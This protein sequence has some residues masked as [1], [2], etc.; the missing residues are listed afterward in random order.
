MS[1]SDDE[2]PI[3][4]SFDSFEDKKCYNLLKIDQKTSELEHSISDYATPSIAVEKSR[5]RELLEA[6]ILQSDFKNQNDQLRR[7]IQEFEDSIEA[8]NLKF[9]SFTKKYET[10]QDRELKQQKKLLDRGKKVTELETFNS[11]LITELNN[12]ISEHSKQ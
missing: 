8:S 3:K 12:Q 2:D 5:F 6:E 7:R 10:L 9:E 1:S 4:S 11:N